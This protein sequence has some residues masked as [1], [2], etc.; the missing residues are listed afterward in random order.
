MFSGYLSNVGPHVGLQHVRYADIGRVR[1]A[2]AL[3]AA[4][5]TSRRKLKTERSLNFE[6]LLLRTWQ[7]RTVFATFTLSTF[8]PAA[9]TT[10]SAVKQHAANYIIAKIMERCFHCKVKYSNIAHRDVSNGNCSLRNFR[11]KKNYCRSNST[12]PKRRCIVVTKNE[13]MITATNMST[14][15]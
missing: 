13:K 15:T 4:V 11:K 3:L 8:I 12:I 9:D 5:I 7:V 1:V 10:T 2:T 6:H 14:S